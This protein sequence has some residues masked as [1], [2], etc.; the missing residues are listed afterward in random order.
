MEYKSKS[1]CAADA[2]TALCAFI[3]MSLTLL[4]LIRYVCELRSL[5]KGCRETKYQLL[6]YIIIWNLCSFLSKGIDLRFNDVLWYT[7]P[8][9]VKF[10][11]QL[12][13]FL[14]LYH[15][16]KRASKGDKN[17]IQWI[18]RIKFIII[19]GM[20]I[21]IIVLLTQILKMVYNKLEMDETE[22]SQL[23]IFIK[24]EYDICHNPQDLICSI[25]QLVLIIIY[26][27][28]IRRRRFLI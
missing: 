9:V 21:N 7:M 3:L 25:Y 10:L 28:Y 23:T 6:S 20:I 14:L 18:C 16:F 26:G 8:L 19:L 15:F 13:S 2:V 11:Y 22:S 24:D 12:A 5:R 1:Q 17:R 4:V 27:C